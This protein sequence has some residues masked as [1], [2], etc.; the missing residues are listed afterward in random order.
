MSTSHVDDSTHDTI[1]TGA[2]PGTSGA[3]RPVVF[4][5][6]VLLG[7]FLLF[8]VQ[9]MIAR[10]LLP[11]FGGGPAVWSTCLMFFQVALV[12]GYAYA[13]VAR[14]LGVRRQ[15]WLH[16]ALLAAAVAA[17][18]IVPSEAFKPIDGS[19]PVGRLLVVLCVTV[20]PPFVLL[21][22]TA[23]LL[24]DWF[25]QALPGRSPYPLYVVSNVG[26]LAALLCYPS[27]V[28]PT[29]TLDRQA[30][31]WSAGF[32]LFG[33]LAAWCGWATAR[34]TSRLA[35]GSAGAARAADGAPGAGDRGAGAGTGAVGLELDGTG[36]R[37]ADRALWLLLPAIGTAVLVATTNQLSQDVAAL[38]LIW[39]APLALYLLT[40]IAAFGGWYSRHV[41]G[42]VMI[43]AIA[44]ALY[45]IRT[46]TGW[47]LRVQVTWLLAAMAAA[48]FLCHGEL[49]RLRPRARHLTAFYLSLSAG[50][51]VGGSFGAIGAPLLFTRHIELPLLFCTAIG[52]LGAISARHRVTGAPYWRRW[53]AVAALGTPILAGTV[54][55]A[56]D[57]GWSNEI[58]RHRNFYGVL[59]VRQE[60]LGVPMPM[61]LLYHGR[62]LHGGQYL[63]PEKHLE[64]TT[65]Y[66]RPTGAGEALAGHPKRRAGEPLT[67]GS[68]GLGTGALAAW[69]RAGDTFRFYEID[70]DVIQ[71]ARTLFT[72]LSESP[73]TI[74]VVPGDGR[75][76]LERELR[77]P[78]A[79]HRYDVFVLD[80]FSG[81]AI[82][83][84]LMTRE[85]FALYR[86]A[87]APGGILA[88]HV[89]NRYLDLRPVVYGLAEETGL[90]VIPIALAP[91]PAARVPGSTWL[92]LTANHTFIAAT[93]PRPPIGPPT[94]RRIVWT[95]DFSSL[96]SLVRWSGDEDL[97]R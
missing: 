12:A 47:S 31:W 8:F 1:D 76:A 81:D 39:I 56:N 66:V 41:T 96:L 44:M 92:L 15:A 89:S 5:A 59:R 34:A 11:W 67:V 45:A 16:V 21:A 82:P 29:M 7:A 53:A 26:A 48:C 93:T 30:L 87:L 35:A 19:D 52:V 27:I 94:T 18:P 32:V 43:V 60:P 72:F 13:H 58:A 88:V 70:P 2:A 83:V 4:H 84:H 57:D 91:V 49:A 63:A 51:A 73:A 64:P 71:V 74:D 36:V 38:P 77:D 25:S 97:E 54:L 14:R 20:G 68:I 65:Y 42:L 3:V 23:P 90:T 86:E 24:Q 50:G 69:A 78:S 17:L 80:A 55:V 40:Y 33:G 22:A 46:Q 95:D 61:R 85:A 28:E 79:R 37:A 6:A 9:P 62:V 75:L 10:R